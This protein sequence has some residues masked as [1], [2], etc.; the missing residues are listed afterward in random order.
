M[1]RY[2]DRAGIRSVGTGRQASKFQSRWGEPERKQLMALLYRRPGE[3]DAPRLKSTRTSLPEPLAP[4]LQ[5]P[6]IWS[7]PVLAY[8]SWPPA[9]T[10]RLGGLPLAIERQPM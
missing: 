6:S 10:A 5:W 8:G 2:G 3:A 9:A 7:V 4:A 1:A